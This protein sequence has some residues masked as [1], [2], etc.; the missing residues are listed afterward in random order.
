[1]EILEAFDLTRC[2]HSAAEPAGV[3]EKDSDPLRRVPRRVFSLF[4]PGQRTGAEVALSD[5]SP[6]PQGE[7]AIPVDECGLSGRCCSYYL[8][9]VLVA[10]VVDA[11]TSSVELTSNRR[12][13]VPDSD[14][15]VV[16]PCVRTH[17]T[18]EIGLLASTRLDD[19]R[20]HL[21]RW[22]VP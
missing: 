22:H 6:R 12:G 16:I 9:M 21:S 3:D 15:I 14:R 8:S 5:E 10:D 13:A 20:S 2:V 17:G 11:D 18:G 7:P 1:M 19:G 4:Q